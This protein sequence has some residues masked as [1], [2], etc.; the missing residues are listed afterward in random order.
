MKEYRIQ[1]YALLLVLLMLSGCKNE[2]RPNYSY[3]VVE[4]EED[5]LPYGATDTIDGIKVSTDCAIINF[6]HELLQGKVENIA[7]PSML[8][9]VKA[10][11]Q[12]Y[13]DS[14]SVGI[15]SLP[16]EEAA[17]I[18]ATRAHITDIYRSKCRQYEVPAESVIGNLRSCINQVNGMHTKGELA[19]FLDVRGGMLSEIDDIHLCIESSSNRIDEARRLAAQLKHDVDKK[20]KQFGL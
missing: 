10:C 14:L 4:E 5:A 7:S 12:H 8:T 2:K 19:R 17:M 15:E 1:L 18:N 6:E 16:A 3:D 11:F 9:R 13:M 20:K